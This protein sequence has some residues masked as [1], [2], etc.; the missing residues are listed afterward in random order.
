MLDARPLAAYHGP[1]PLAAAPVVVVELLADDAAAAALLSAVP[2]LAEATADWY[3]PPQ[4]A[5]GAALEVVGGFLADWALQA[6][7]FVNGYLHD[8]GCL[9]DPVG[10]RAL[11]WVGFHRPRLSAGAVTLAADWLTALASGTVDAAD[12]RTELEELWVGCR[13]A[14]PDF[15]A[16][17]VMQAARARGIPVA[18]AWGLPRFWRFGQGEHATVLFESSSGRDGRYG[19]WIA[20]SK[21]TTKTVL[22]ALGLPGPDSRLVADVGDLEEAVA[23]IGFPCVTKPTDNGGGR[24]VS[25]GLEDLAALRDGFAAARRFTRGPILVEAHVTGEDHR[26]MVVDGRFVGAFRRE[27]PTVTGDG[28]RTIAELVAA[29]NVSR[30]ARSLVRSGYLRPVVLDASALLHLAGLGLGPD[31]VP[32]DG[33][34]VRVRSNANLSTG[35]DCVDV[36]DQVH[37]GWQAMTETLG[38]TLNL[39]MLGVDVLTHDIGRGPADGG[40]IIEINTTPGLEVLIVAGWA[41][42]RVG[43]LALGD[44]TARI[45]V[46]LLIVGADMLDRT[47]AAARDRD[48]PSGSGW[49]AWDRG[50]NGASPVWAEDDWPWPAVRALLEHRTLTRLVVIA[51]DSQIYEHGLPGDLF[52]A[53]CLACDLLALW[54]PVLRGCCPDVRPVDDRGADPAVWLDVVSAASAPRI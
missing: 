2:A 12:H 46:R 38:R 4:P 28:R 16:R 33:E 1:N 5:Q 26:L 7:T 39:P 43:A 50:A 36:T 29:L 24:G 49:A 20:G 30:D 44:G 10:G 41:V 51:A 22:A 23:E 45:P 14:H 35:G 47:L 27:P 32:A 31:A 9:A 34:T 18:P 21:A 8:A 52:D 25:T 6:L 3:R 11:A 19:S 42:E 48:W 13:D 40:Q 37:P 17:I 53:A 54:D 15:Q